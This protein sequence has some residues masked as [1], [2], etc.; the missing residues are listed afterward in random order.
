[1]TLLVKFWPLLQAISS[2][3]SKHCRA[4]VLRQLKKNKDFVACLR[5]IATNAVRGNVVL[6]KTDKHKLNKHAK[7]I[8]ALTRSRSVEQAGGFLGAIV[9]IL[10]AIAFELINGSKKS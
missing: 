10:A 3:K 1:M 2:I 7:V 6:S 4:Q 8:K 5:E 9:P